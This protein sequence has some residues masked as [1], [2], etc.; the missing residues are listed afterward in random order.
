[1]NRRAAVRVVP[2][3]LLVTLVLAGCCNENWKG[4]GTV[5][6]TLTITGSW[7]RGDINAITVQTIDACENKYV[8][9]SA[10]EGP[11][12][13]AVRDELLANGTYTVVLEEHEIIAGTTLSRWMVREATDFRSLYDTRW[14][15]EYK[16]K[17]NGEKVLA[18][19]YAFP[20]SGS[21]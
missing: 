9:F 10:L 12:L 15:S 6:G 17:K 3:L 14:S 11:D 1:M 8:H 18:I 19:T 16:L 5:S 13:D 21:H 2:G 4:L 20:E 7:E